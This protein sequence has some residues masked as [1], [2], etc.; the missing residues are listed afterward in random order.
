MIAYHVV[1]WE[2]DIKELKVFFERY[3]DNMPDILTD[4]LDK[5]KQHLFIKYIM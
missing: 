2:P 4:N 1:C 3:N 5:T